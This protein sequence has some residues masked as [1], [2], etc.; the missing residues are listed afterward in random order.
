MES[1]EQAEALYSEGKYLQSAH[2]YQALLRAE[3]QSAQLHQALGEALLQARHFAEALQS[4]DEV[5]RLDPGGHGQGVRYWL[6]RAE[7][8]EE[9]GRA[10]EALRSLDEVLT[11]NPTSQAA[12]LGKGQ[13]LCEFSDPVSLA[14]G[15]ELIVEVTQEL[16]G[17]AAATITL[18]Q[19]LLRIETLATADE[20]MAFADQLIH[21]F[22]QS[23][24]LHL[25]RAQLCKEQGRLDAALRI[26][27][28]ALALD[29]QDPEL[30]QALGELQQ[31]LGDGEG[32]QRRLEEAL[33]ILQDQ[34]AVAAAPVEEVERRRLAARLRRTGEVLRRLGRRDEALSSYERALVLTPGDPVVWRALG[35]LHREAGRTL[36]AVRCYE[37]ALTQDPSDVHSAFFLA[38]T[39]REA[40]RLD[41]ALEVIEEALG[42]APDWG[43]GHKLH[44]HLL[45]RA[46]RFEDAALAYGRCAIEEEED[47][48]AWYLRGLAL[49]HLGDLEEAQHALEVALELDPIETDALLLQAEVLVSRGYAQ[50]ADE[51]YEQA[52]RAGLEAA[53][54]HFRRG[55]AYLDHGDIVEALEA[56]RTIGR[57]SPN[58]GLDLL[59]YA[60]IAALEG[61]L[62]KARELV[63][64][65][66]F[67]EPTL[68]ELAQQQS[69]LAQVLAEHASHVVVEAA[70][71]RAERSPSTRGVPP[72]EGE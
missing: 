41:E 36:E 13:I 52:I 8:L 2:Q 17:Q 62:D 31:E 23:L 29:E 33:R 55:A 53:T 57:L 56:F 15:T 6:S 49:R 59:G 65:A 21:H 12:R 61:E 45:M 43:L 58:S 63:K 16:Y 40:G 27:E 50:S 51:H 7:A 3:P 9:L 20:R 44:G 68:G 47:A 25:L 1:V 24:P 46:E 34:V 32:A 38:H 28:R 5:L 69:A 30:L 71:L 26:L 72:D 35:S 37:E 14:R 39:L 64:S 10:E 66:L 4:F 54:V 60:C 22:P 67:L 48:E 19:Q 11:R 70:R 18:R 42:A